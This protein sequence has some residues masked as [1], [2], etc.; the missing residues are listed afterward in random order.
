MH[1]TCAVYL[2]KVSGTHPRQ[3]PLITPAPTL[4]RARR[5]VR[6]SSS[7]LFSRCS[8]RT[9]P[10]LLSKRPHAWSDLLALSAAA[11]SFCSRLHSLARSWFGPPTRPSTSRVSVCV[12]VCVCM[13]MLRV[14]ALASSAQMPLPRVIEDYI[15]PSS[16]S[17]TA[18]CDLVTTLRD[19]VAPGT[20]LTSRRK[21]FSDVFVLTCLLV[22]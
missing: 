12:C 7:L 8:D 3:L 22:W 13:A 21:E 10:L 11:P 19:V 5:A 1:C 15:I 2:R 17:I 20:V 16:A 18:A 4:S 6:A 9:L 14:P